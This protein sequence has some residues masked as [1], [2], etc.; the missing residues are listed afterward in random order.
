M[1]LGPTGRYDV[2]NIGG[3]QGRAFIPHDLPPVR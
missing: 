1:K 2:Q 3:E